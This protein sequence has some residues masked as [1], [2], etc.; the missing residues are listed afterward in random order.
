MV[1][2][3]DAL[4]AAGSSPTLEAIAVAG[5]EEVLYHH[6]EAICQSDVLDVAATLLIAQWDNIDQGRAA[7]LVISGLRAT[8]VPLAFAGTLEAISGHRRYSRPSPRT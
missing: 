7:N 4:R 1:T 8:A 6:A 5:G 2:I 3:I